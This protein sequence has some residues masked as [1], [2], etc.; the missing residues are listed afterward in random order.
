MSIPRRPS[1][2]P[3][4]PVLTAPRFFEQCKHLSWLPDPTFIKPV[5]LELVE[6]RF[7]SFLMASLA[8]FLH[9]K[10]DN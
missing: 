9:W 3:L 10:D 4:P 1:L 7:P 5:S 6:G 2:P 8:W